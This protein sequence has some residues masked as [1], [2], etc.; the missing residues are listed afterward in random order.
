[1]AS[2]PRE[3]ERTREWEEMD[4]LEQRNMIMLRKLWGIKMNG[5]WI[6]NKLVG[7]DCDDSI[8]ILFMNLPMTCSISFKGLTYL[9]L[10]EA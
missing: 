4:G 8:R 6:V 7:S 1:M 10:C 2:Q 3:N 9:I 5:K